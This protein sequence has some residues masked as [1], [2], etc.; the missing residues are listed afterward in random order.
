MKGGSASNVRAFLDGFGAHWAFAELDLGKVMEREKTGQP[1]ACLC[2][3][4]VHAFFQDWEAELS[5][6]TCA[7]QS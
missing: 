7:M 2:T 5:A 4:L 1:S 6:E 3:E